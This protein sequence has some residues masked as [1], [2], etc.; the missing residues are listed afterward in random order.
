MAY[1]NQNYKINK[2]IHDEIIRRRDKIHGEFTFI[3]VDT[4][5]T[6]VAD[7]EIIVKEDGQEQF[8]GVTNPL[9]ILFFEDFATGV[10]S[11]TISKE[12]YKTIQKNDLTVVDLPAELTVTIEEEEPGPGPEP[13]T[14]FN[15]FV[16]DENNNK[17]NDAV[18][19]LTKDD[20]TVQC[21][22][23]NEGYC[24]FK[25]LAEGQYTIL[26]MKGGYVDYTN[27][28]SVPKTTT[29]F[30]VIME[31]SGDLAET[32]II[33]LNINRSR[34]YMNPL[35][36]MQYNPYYEC[37][38]IDENSTPLM[39]SMTITID[40]ESHEI[41]PI[42]IP[43]GVCRFDISN[44][45]LGEHSV[46]VEFSGD[47]DYAPTQIENTIKI[48]EHNSD[49]GC[50]IFTDAKDT[51][52]QL[53]EVPV[54]STNPIEIFIAD[55]N[56]MATDAIVYLND[57]IEVVRAND[58]SAPLYVDELSIGTYNMII[59]HKEDAETANSNILT[60]KLKIY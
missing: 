25:N 1:K 35:Q 51:L 2:K 56:W 12:G 39:K 34:D 16:S 20:S 14:F 22:T 58:D 41:T 30:D 9:G 23:K 24:T 50:K 42:E 57:D 18:I 28:V 40:G 46:I 26:V 48:F 19:E 6:P 17:I 45:S 52:G 13:D 29:T 5:N 55:P 3:V 21:I 10:Y 31:A 37:I 60:A 8:K 53:I 15:V 11:C 4:T 33:G 54:G 59:Y 47:N 49:A 32:E 43:K 27:T 38:L 44:L 7:V 36:P